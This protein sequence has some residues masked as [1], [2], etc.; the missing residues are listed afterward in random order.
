MGDSLRVGVAC[1]GLGV[2]VPIGPQ[3]LS[4][5]LGPEPLRQLN[6]HLLP[7]L[8][9]QLVRC[10][11]EGGGRANGA[12]VH[13]GRVGVVV[14]VLAPVPWDEAIPQR[15]GV[16]AAL[17]TVQ[18]SALGGHVLRE[19]AGGPGGQLLVPKVTIEVLEAARTHGGVN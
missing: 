8:V 11:D 4:G 19:G 12:L 16:V 15:G 9:E 13:T 5:D 10:Q 3:V 18:G 7:H 1:Q 6:V 17:R 14:S 2:S